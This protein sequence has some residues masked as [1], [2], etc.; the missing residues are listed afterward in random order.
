LQVVNSEQPPSS[1]INIAYVFEGTVP[2]PPEKS[3]PAYADYS[4]NFGGSV[5]AFTVYLYGHWITPADTI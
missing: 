2:Q 5:I 4:A 3:A 1:S